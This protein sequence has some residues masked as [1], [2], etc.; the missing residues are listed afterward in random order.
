MKTE[1]DLMDALI[2]LLGDTQG[3]PPEVIQKLKADFHR[4]FQQT[5]PKPMTEAEYTQALAQ[6]RRE[7]PAYLASLGH[8]PQPSP[9]GGTDEKRRS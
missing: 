9:E 3:A 4:R 7:F 8:G 2:V 1:A 6:L 5:P